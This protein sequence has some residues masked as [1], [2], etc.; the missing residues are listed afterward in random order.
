[1]KLQATRYNV[2]EKVY[3]HSNS[4]LAYAHRFIPGETVFGTVEWGTEWAVEPV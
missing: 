3:L 4:T 1:M 2:G